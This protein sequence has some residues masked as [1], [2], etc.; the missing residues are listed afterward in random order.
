MWSGRNEIVVTGDRPDLLAEVRRHWLPAAVVAWGEPDDGPLFEGRPP[1]PGLAY[2][3]QGALVPDAGG[4][5]RDPGRPVGGA[6]RMSAPVVDPG[7]GD[8]RRRR[9]RTQR[10]H[11]GRYRH[12]RVTD[13]DT[14]GDTGARPGRRTP[15][16]DGAH[17]A[18]DTADER[19]R[20]R[21]DSPPQ[22]PTTPDRPDA[23]PPPLGPPQGAR[24]DRRRLHAP[25]PRPVL[26]ARGHHRRRPGHPHGH[27]GP[28][29]R[30][31]R[32][33]SPTSAPSTSWR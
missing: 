15:A 16:H 25:S 12:G 27:A 7:T 3:C 8:G 14:D 2:V 30:G 29:A 19:D 31:P 18:D 26:H 20:D 21:R 22:H 11:V 4:G 28:R 32:G 33:T 17:G 1:E 24:P 5:R 10:R 23:P 13:T 9:R 6:G